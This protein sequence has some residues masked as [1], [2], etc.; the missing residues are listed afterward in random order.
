MVFRRARNFYHLIDSAVTTNFYCFNMSLKWPLLPIF[1]PFP[2]KKSLKV[3]RALRC[4]PSAVRDPREQAQRRS[5]GQQGVVAPAP[6]C[7][8]CAHRRASSCD[9]TDDD[10]DPDVDGDAVGELRADDEWAVAYAY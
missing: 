6:A 4:A 2:P 9:R 5:D 10:V 7:G 3:K 8:D 1:I